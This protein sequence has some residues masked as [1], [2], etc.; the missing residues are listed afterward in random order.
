MIIPV[1]KPINNEEYILFI[2]ILVN[3]IQTP[4]EN[5]NIHK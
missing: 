3:S 1:P 5:N 2:I 4:K